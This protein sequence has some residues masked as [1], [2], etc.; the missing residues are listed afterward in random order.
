MEI[1]FYAALGKIVNVAKILIVCSEQASSAVMHLSGFGCTL[2]KSESSAVLNEI[3]PL[4]P[5]IVCQRKNVIMNIV[6]FK[7]CND[8]KLIPCNFYR[9]WPR[10]VLQF[11][12]ATIST[13]YGIL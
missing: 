4:F 7:I 1:N 8:K 13:L 12:V 3:F 10:A 11:A 6:P 5:R 2:L 9:L